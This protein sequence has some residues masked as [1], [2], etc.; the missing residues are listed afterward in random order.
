MFGA[1]SLY[2]RI[3][4]GK[5]EE[6][7]GAHILHPGTEVSTDTYFNIF[8]SSKYNK[9]TIIENVSITTSV[10]GNLCVELHRC[11]E[12]QDE[13]IDKKR[14]ISDN[15]CTVT[16]S[17]D[18]T[19]SDD[20]DPACHYISYKS[21]ET[22]SIYS[23][24]SYTADVNSNY[25]DLGLVICTF[26]RESRILETLTR[27]H[28]VLDNE[29]YALQGPV[30]IYLVDNGRTIDK[31]DILYDYVKLIPNDNHGGSGGFAR[32]MMEAREENKTHIILMDDDI[33]IDPNVIF[34][35]MNFISVLKNEYK[36]VFVLGGML[37]PEAPTIQYEAGARWYP[38]FK[39]GKHLIDLSLPDSLLL[40]DKY[41]SA[42]YGG[43]WYQSM[44]ISATEELPLPLFLKMDDI[45]FCLRRMNNHVVMNGIGIWHDSFESKI[46]PVI[47]FYYLRRNTLIIDSIH[48]SKGGFKVGTEYLRTML[49][50]IKEGKQE[51]FF[52]TKMAVE[53]YL[54][55]PDFLSNIDDDA[56]LNI[57]SP[58]DMTTDSKGATTVKILRNSSIK[59]LISLLRS[60]LALMFKTR[61]LS[62]KY[63]NSIEYLSSSEY[64]KNR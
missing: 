18:I 47:D 40:N 55:G 13:I 27:I 3:K 59:E 51:E 19:E 45:I 16:F 31:K 25:V 41:E 37:L 21:V 54:K 12:L 60:G 7:D 46:S 10:S 29:S 6:L 39:R 57:Q 9:Y 56:I 23:F 44:P 53:D 50:C 36:D 30:T 26:R 4:S 14:I 63:I 49:H 2:L 61:T 38:T 24:G 28:N 34:K 5:V 64:W 17:F 32:G 58:R 1:E 42:Q 35:T 8:S 20:Y 52:Y 11:S 33:C 48:G 62:K 15:M 43:W 22:S